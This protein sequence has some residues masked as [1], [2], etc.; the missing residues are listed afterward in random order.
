MSQL[1]IMLSESHTCLDYLLIPDLERHHA[2]RMISL[3]LSSK[4]FRHIA[5]SISM[6]RNTRIQFPL[7]KR[8]NLEEL[9]MKIISVAS[10]IYRTVGNVSHQSFSAFQEIILQWLRSIKNE[11]IAAPRP[12]QNL[13]RNGNGKI[14]GRN[15]RR[16]SGYENI[17]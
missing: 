10:C 17:L 8:A 15:V 12:F 16:S 11:Y 6:K 2:D 1:F 7:L 14:P 5:S 3:C 4:L 9:P 13:I